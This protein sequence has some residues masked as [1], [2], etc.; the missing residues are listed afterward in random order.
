MESLR[1]EIAEQHN[2]YLQNRNQ[3]MYTQ[4]MELKKETPHNQKL[5]QE[6]QDLKKKFDNSLLEK[7]EE[8][9]R[10]KDC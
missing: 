8:I 3:E 10:L 6:N 5:Q 2:S 9:S 7:G 4:I 1:C